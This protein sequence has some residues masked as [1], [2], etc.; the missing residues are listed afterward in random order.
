MAFFQEIPSIWKGHFFSGL[1]R[2]FLNDNVAGVQLLYY[3]EF[4]SV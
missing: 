2:F 1:F 4:S 3:S